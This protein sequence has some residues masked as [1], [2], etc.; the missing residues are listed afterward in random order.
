VSSYVAAVPHSDGG[1]TC[2]HARCRRQAAVVQALA[3]EGRCA[4]AEAEVSAR[5]DTIDW[6]EHVPDG[7]AER[8]QLL[9]E[10]ELIHHANNGSPQAQ[11]EAG[12]RRIKHADKA[13]TAKR[14]RRITAIDNERTEAIATAR[15]AALQR[16]QVA[17]AEHDHPHYRCATHAGDV[18]DADGAAAVRAASS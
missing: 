3:C 18:L 17:I 7:L 2:G 10:L 13:E 4:Q 6:A 12:R 5:I 16:A 15:S 11:Y 9:A 14:K 1:H 8:G